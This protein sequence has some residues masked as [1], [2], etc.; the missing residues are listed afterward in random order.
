MS[1]FASDTAASTASVM[2]SPATKRE[3]NRRATPFRR[4]KLKTFFCSD[5][6]S[7]P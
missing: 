2:D 7:S 5:S 6:Q 3:A 1:F 4:T